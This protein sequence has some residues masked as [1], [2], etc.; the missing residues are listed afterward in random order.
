[1]SVTEK[2]NK[3]DYMVLD[4]NWKLSPGEEEL[5]DSCELV[6]EPVGDFYRKL[7]QDFTISYQ[8]R[9]VLG[10]NSFQVHYNFT[11]FSHI[12][13]LRDYRP[14]TKVLYQLRINRFNKY[15]GCLVRPLP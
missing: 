11:S 4:N 3:Y 8:D 1:M 13:F 10:I 12:S 15:Y 5:L 2:F 7:K 9:L 6:V 14:E